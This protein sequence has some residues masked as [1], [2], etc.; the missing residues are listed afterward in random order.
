[1][2]NIR[3]QRTAALIPVLDAFVPRDITSQIV[4]LVVEIEEVEYIE[5]YMGKVYNYVIERTNYWREE[6][7]ALDITEDDFF[8]RLI[9]IQE[10]L[11][12]LGN[13]RCVLRKLKF[14][15]YD[16]NIANRDSRIVVFHTFK[17]VYNKIQELE[18]NIYFENN[19][20]STSL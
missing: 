5:K 17:E 12:V 10:Y 7:I 20:T 1:M 19:I 13:S 6:A 15:E 8:D 2:N 9:Q 14:F 4:G 3:N 18:R 11:G 16:T